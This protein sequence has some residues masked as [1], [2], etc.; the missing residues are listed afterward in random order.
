MA[1]AGSRR[2]PVDRGTDPLR[3]NTDD[4]KGPIVFMASNAS[5]YMTGANGV[6]DGGWTAW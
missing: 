1:M 5:G 3:T 4:V 2:F 6:F